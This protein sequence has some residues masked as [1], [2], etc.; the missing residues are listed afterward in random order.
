MWT[1]SL[2]AFPES[3]TT[4]SCARAM[5]DNRET[6]DVIRYIRQ[7]LNEKTLTAVPPRWQQQV[8]RPLVDLPIQSLERYGL[9]HGKKG[10]ICRCHCLRC[11]YSPPV[12]VIRHM[13]DLSNNGHNDEL[14]GESATSV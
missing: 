3:Y 11:H 2:W 10:F 12:E 9:P 7:L 4:G 6:K 13:D 14:V 1:E 8:R 5:A